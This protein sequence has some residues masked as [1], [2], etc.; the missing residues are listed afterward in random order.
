MVNELKN[1]I[2]HFF[3]LVVRTIRDNIPKLIGFFLV[4]GV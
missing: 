3:K 2:E 4:K 1:K